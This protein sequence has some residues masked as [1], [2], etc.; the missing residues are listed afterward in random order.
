MVASCPEGGHYTAY[1]NAWRGSRKET[2]SMS[3]V[4][5][6]GLR[7]TDRPVA[8][9]TWSVH[10]DSKKAKKPLTRRVL[11]ERLAKLRAHGGFYIYPT[12]GPGPVPELRC[13]DSNLRNCIKLDGAQ[14]VGR[15]PVPPPP[16][17]CRQRVDKR[18]E[19]IFRESREERAEQETT[20]RDT[21]SRRSLQPG[22]THTATSELTD[23]VDG[24]QLGRCHV[25]ISS[26]Y[27]AADR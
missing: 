21:K 12:S 2:P 8:K 1:P 7:E 5:H 19:W 4:L 13:F 26:C 25:E 3:L 6:N 23:P 10:V 27:K 11:S 24:N 14:L 16:N 22:E 17:T 20:S 15:L 18:L 9:M